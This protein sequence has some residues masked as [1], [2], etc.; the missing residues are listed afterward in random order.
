MSAAPEVAVGEHVY[1]IRKLDPMRQFHVVRR[2][3]PLLV[4]LGFTADGTVK[5][6][7]QNLLKSLSGPAEAL[8]MM[9]DADAEYVIHTCLIAVD[10]KAKNGFAP[11]IQ[12][13]ANMFSADMDAGVMLQL[14]W[15]VGKENLAGFMATFQSRAGSDKAAAE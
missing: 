4:S 6:K 3:A 7:A 14:V 8:A 5:S 2:I 12:G 10:R 9:S 13:G 15:E 1:R 11:V